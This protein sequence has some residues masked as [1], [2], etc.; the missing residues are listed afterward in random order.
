[1]PIKLTWRVKQKMSGFALCTFSSFSLHTLLLRQN[2][3]HWASTA[4]F[5][6]MS[7]S[8]RWCCDTASSLPLWKFLSHPRDIF[9]PTYVS[10][11]DWPWLS[12]HPM[13]TWQYCC[14]PSWTASHIIIII[15]AASPNGKI[16]APLLFYS[17]QYCQTGW[18]RV[19]FWIRLN[20]VCLGVENA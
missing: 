10:S 17:V 3:Y 4:P 8:I 9:C 1:M 12:I 11:S 20:K 13:N 18:E 16:P 2:F 19:S 14:H 7:V 6:F 15:S 5:I